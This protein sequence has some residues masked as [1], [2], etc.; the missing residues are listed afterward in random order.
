M[1]ENDVNKATSSLGHNRLDDLFVDAEDMRDEY[2]RRGF[3]HADAGFRYDILNDTLPSLLAHLTLKVRRSV[4][5]KSIAEA[6]MMAKDSEE[7][8][9][10]VNARAIAKADAL[11]AKY[12]ADAQKMYSEFVRSNVTTHRE[13]A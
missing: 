11:K 3:A 1:S 4:P 13:M 7:Y 6:E 10:Q 5:G 9:K 12:A 2:E 8:L